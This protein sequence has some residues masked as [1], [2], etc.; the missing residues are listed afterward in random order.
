MPYNVPRV[1]KICA[2]ILSR[3]V[4][5]VDVS[6]DKH[7]SWFNDENFRSYFFESYPYPH[8]FS[9]PLSLIQEVYT[10]LSNRL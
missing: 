2:C 1:A 3:G 7:I 10:L 5:V 4:F 9:L 6:F 8:I